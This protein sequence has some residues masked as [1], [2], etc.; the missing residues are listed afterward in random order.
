M[1]EVNDAIQLRR[2]GG[3][4][5]DDPSPVLRR[6]REVELRPEW[7]QREP[8]E[9]ALRGNSLKQLRERRCAALFCLGMS[10]AL[11]S[12]VQFAQVEADDHDFVTRHVAADTMIFTPVQLKELVPARLNPAATLDSL[13]SG[14]SRYGDMGRTVVAIQWNRREL[15]QLPLAREL[16]LQ[17]GGVWLFGASS[18]DQREWF[19]IGDL[20]DRPI[21]YSFEYPPGVGE[22]TGA[23][24]GS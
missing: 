8:N 4:K 23:H 3:L 14:L 22:Y 18:P 11:E 15:L 1:N 12:P 20:L 17:C 21:E 13:L 24:V 16:E 19:L 2:W 7:H 6:L 5:F 9:R 10:N